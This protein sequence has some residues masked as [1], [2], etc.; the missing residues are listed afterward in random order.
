MIIGDP[1]QDHTDPIG[2][3]TQGQEGKMRQVR[4]KERIK[5]IS[6]LRAVSLGDGLPDPRGAKMNL[7]VTR[8]R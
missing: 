6:T 8:M 1:R 3:W 4:R 7:R 2:V 5:L